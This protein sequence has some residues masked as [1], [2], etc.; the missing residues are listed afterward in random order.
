[1]EGS[2]EGTPLCSSESEGWGESAVHPRVVRKGRRPLVA[3][4]NRA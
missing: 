4:E 1:M 2:E 3:R